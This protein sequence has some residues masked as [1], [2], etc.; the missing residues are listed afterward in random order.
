MQ[1]LMWVPWR[2]VKA[3]EVKKVKVEMKKVK[4]EDVKKEEEEEVVDLEEPVSFRAVM[5]RMYEEERREERFL[6][7]RIERG[8]RSLEAEFKKEKSEEWRRRRL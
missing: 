8:R 7:K 1:N 2:E 4:V 6:K 3:E 5:A